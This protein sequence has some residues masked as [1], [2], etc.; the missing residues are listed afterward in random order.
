MG[1]IGF[2][3]EREEKFWFASAC[4]NFKL[5]IINGVINIGL[6]EFF[7][8]DA[9]QMRHSEC[10]TPAVFSTSQVSLSP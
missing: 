10:I 1:G 3:K 4:K 7:A 2:E 9:F 5:D 8:W 6:G